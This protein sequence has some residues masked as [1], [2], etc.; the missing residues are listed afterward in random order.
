[1]Q[2]HNLITTSSVILQ[3]YLAADFLYTPAFRETKASKPA[4]LKKLYV[5]PFKLALPKVCFV[6]YV[7]H[8]FIYSFIYFEK[9]HSQ[10][11]QP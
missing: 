11:V 1:M 10:Y 3:G 8:S 7:V 4:S 9:C 6:Y 2:C 5:F